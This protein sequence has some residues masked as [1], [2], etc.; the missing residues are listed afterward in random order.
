MNAWRVVTVVT[1]NSAAGGLGW[2]IASSHAAAAIILC[3]ELIS[4]QAMTSWHQGRRRDL[5][6][7]ATGSV[8]CCCCCSSGGGGQQSMKINRR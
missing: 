3:A 1:N 2:M 7:D 6:L 5:D 8:V 4:I